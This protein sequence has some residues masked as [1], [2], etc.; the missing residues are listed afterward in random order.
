[1]CS[2]ELRQEIEWR[3]DLKIPIRARFEVVGPQVGKGST[4][5]LLGLVDNLSGIGYL[6]QPR[7][8]PVGS[9]PWTVPDAQSLLGPPRTKARR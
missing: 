3:E 7:Q 4:S 8:A 5:L 1:M 9:G 2:H 6:D